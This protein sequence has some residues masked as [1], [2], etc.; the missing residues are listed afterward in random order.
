MHLNF[1]VRQKIKLLLGLSA[2]VAIGTLLLVPTIPQDPAYHQFADQTAY[3]WVPNFWNVV[4]NVPFMLIGLAGMLAIY[5]GKL[6]ILP[7][8]RAGYLAFFIGVAL[9]GP[10]SAY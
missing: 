2:L 10:G 4:S 3:W 1:S 7:E 6:T 8:L 5:Q 9:V